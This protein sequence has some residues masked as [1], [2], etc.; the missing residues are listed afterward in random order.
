MQVS[1]GKVDLSRTSILLVDDNTTSLDLMQQIL[2]GLRVGNIRTANNPE[3]A[4]DVASRTRFNLMIID[5]EMPNE[6]GI[7]VTRQIRAKQDLPN[8]STPIIVLTAHTPMDKVFRSRDAGANLVVKKP[9]SPAILLSRIQWLGKNGRPFVISDSYIG[10]DRRIRKMPLPDGVTE[11]RAE[12]LAL[13]ANADH[14]MS[15]DEVDALFG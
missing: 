10:P 14:Q 15:Q 1:S 9:V 8:F 7:Q 2:T 11:R 3:E 13:T 5:G 12:A 6:D 4:R